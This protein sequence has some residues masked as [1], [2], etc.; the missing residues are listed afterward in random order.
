[1]DGKLVAEAIPYK[2]FWEKIKIVAEC[3]YKKGKVEVCDKF[4][5]VEYRG[6]KK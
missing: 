2:T 3:L 5:Y 6:D 1:M 4:I